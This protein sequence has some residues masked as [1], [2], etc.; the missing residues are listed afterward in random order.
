MKDP[1]DI[2]STFVTNAR[3]DKDVLYKKGHAHEGAEPFLVIMNGSE[4]GRK[5]IL[6]SHVTTIGRSSRNHIQIA[7]PLV[8]SSHAEIRIEKT[9][10]IFCDRKSKNGSMVGGKKVEECL[11]EDGIRITLGNTEL[12]YS[13][14]KRE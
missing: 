3:S 5:L 9:K 10:V 6:L 1:K 11:L 4:K 13:A 14:S 8:S 12:M 2:E 7:D